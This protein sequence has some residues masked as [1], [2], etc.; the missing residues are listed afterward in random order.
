MMTEAI[1]HQRCRARA[2][3]EDMAVWRAQQR[4]RPAAELHD[5]QCHPDWEYET[6][7]GQRKAWDDQ[8]TPPPGGGWV[9]NTFTCFGE[10]WERFDYT[11]ESYWMRPLRADVPYPQFMPAP[12]RWRGC[13]QL[14]EVVDGEGG[15]EARY[16]FVEAGEL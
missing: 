13:Y 16:E 9:R 14:A 5:D 3:D 8:N 11:E 15:R 1:E 7:T 10:G 4:R 12:W 6:T 2:G